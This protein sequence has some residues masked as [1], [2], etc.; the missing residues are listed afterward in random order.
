MGTPSFVVIGVTS[1]DAEERLE[2]MRNR[3]DFPCCF[4][5]DRPGE[6]KGEIEIIV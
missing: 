1:R 4:L 3:L 5:V 6:E 2:K